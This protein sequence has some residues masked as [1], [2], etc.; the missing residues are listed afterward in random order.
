LDENSLF[1]TIQLP[2]YHCMKRKLATENQ[3][4]LSKIPS[5][6]SWASVRSFTLNRHGEALSHLGIAFGQLVTSKIETKPH[7][8]CLLWASESRENMSFCSEGELGQRKAAS[9][10]GSLKL[11]SAID[12]S[13][14]IPSVSQQAHF[15]RWRLL[16]GQFPEW[17]L[18]PVIIIT[19]PLWCAVSSADK[20]TCGQ[21]G[22]W[23]CVRHFLVWGRFLITVFIFTGKQAASTTT[24]QDQVKIA[25][26][27]HSVSSCCRLTGPRSGTLLV[28]KHVRV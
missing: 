16:R 24:N 11:S 17:N 1:L 26:A 18:T 3:L 2:G 8:D 19:Q 28:S 27:V 10:T 20:R 23:Q 13:R 5:L 7:A 4:Q 12:E 25:L 21:T 15:L 6:L 9:H 14:R 22:T